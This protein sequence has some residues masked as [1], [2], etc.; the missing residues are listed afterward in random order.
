MKEL[1][2]IPTS[3]QLM[4]FYRIY[5]YQLNNQ[6]DARYVARHNSMVPLYR[7]HGIWNEDYVFTITI[8]S[9]CMKHDNEINCYFYESDLNKFFMDYE[10]NIW[11]DHFR[12]KRDL[13]KYQLAANIAKE[14]IKL[15]I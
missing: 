12:L 14:V 5:K 4:H 1:F 2:M 6:I 3:N 11:D 10:I 13:P 9:Y 8:P 15:Q 7:E